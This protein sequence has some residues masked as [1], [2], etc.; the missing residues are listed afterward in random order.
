M[1]YAWLG[2]ICVIAGGVWKILRLVRAQRQRVQER[3]ELRQER[4]DKR[5]RG[6]FAKPDDPGKN[7]ADE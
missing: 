3:L 7:T 6:L 2:V 4:W 1:D 5:E